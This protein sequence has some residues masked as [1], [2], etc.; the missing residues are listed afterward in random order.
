ME[1][2]VVVI[3][4]EAIGMNVFTQMMHHDAS[5][6]LYPFLLICKPFSE[7]DFSKN[8]YTVQLLYLKVLL[9][10]SFARS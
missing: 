6:L 1:S 7:C 2:A 3:S 10:A 5:S 9:M 8:L 4:V